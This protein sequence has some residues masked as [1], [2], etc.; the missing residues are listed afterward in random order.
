MRNE[1]EK[2][3]IASFSTNTGL[4]FVYTGS[5]GIDFPG[6]RLLVDGSGVNLLAGTDALHRLERSMVVV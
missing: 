4:P 5:S 1:L 6:R 3:I 2:L